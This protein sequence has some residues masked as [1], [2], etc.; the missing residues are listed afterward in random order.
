MIATNIICKNSKATIVKTIESVAQYTDFL[1]ITDTGSND[2]TQQLIEETCKRLNFPYKLTDFTWVDDFSVARNFNFSQVPP[3]ADWLFWLDSD[4]IIETDNPNRMRDL[5]KS[6]PP[7]LGAFWFPYHYAFDEFGNCTTMFIRERL[8]RA[9]F[10]WKWQSRVH[11]TVSPIAQC[12]MAKD[13]SVRLRH[14]SAHGDRSERNFALLYRMLQE[15]PNHLRTWLYLGHQHFA[16]GSWQ[17]AISWYQKFASSPEVLPIERYQAL[18]YASR[19]A[20]SLNNPQLASNFALSALESYPEWGE[21]Y[22]LLSLCYN[23]MGAHAKAVFWGEQSRGKPLPEE[24]IFINPLDYTFNVEVAL[25]EGYAVLGQIDKA[26]KCLETAISIRPIK[27]LK[28]AQ[29][30]TFEVKAREAIVYGLKALCNNLIKEGELIKLQKLVSIFPTWMADVPDTYQMMD[31]IYRTTCNV[32]IPKTETKE[33]KEVVHLGTDFF[34][35]GVL[36]KSYHKELVCDGVL[37]NVDV[38]LSDAMFR[39]E[40]FADS[41]TVKIR[42]KGLRKVSQ[43]ELERAI[44]QPNRNI[45]QLY[46]DEG[47]LTANFNHSVPKNTGLAIRMFLGNA[48]E[49]WDPIFIDKE[50]FGGSEISAAWLLKELSRRGNRTVLYALANGMYDSVLYRTQFNPQHPPCDLFISSRVPQVLDAPI[51]AAVKLLWVHDVHCGAGLTPQI[52]DKIDGIVVLSKWHLRFMKNIYPWLKDCEVVDMRGDPEMYVDDIP[53]QQGYYADQKLNSP[54]RIFI[55]CDAIESQKWEYID[56][57]K[58]KEFPNRFVWM[59]AP[60]RG[61]EQ[62]LDMWEKIKS[63]LP[64]AELKIFYGWQFFDKTLHVPEQKALKER[65]LEKVKQPGVEWVGRVNPERLN[66]ELYKAGLWLYPPPHDFRETC[67]I[68]A[69]EC[70]AAGVLCF[71]RMNGALGEVL[72]DRGVPLPLTSTQDEIVNSIINVLT[73]PLR[74]STMRLE[75]RKWAMQRNYRHLADCFL[76]AYQLCKDEGKK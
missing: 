62:I 63:A 15:D 56:V 24:V 60:D 28:D 34:T 18:T 54:P 1:N 21:A 76:K 51:P 58:P 44:A 29:D 14:I 36:P 64:G 72:G 67:C 40:T 7:E 49:Y 73:D 41:I 38:A 13:A 8:L 4:D 3:E 69:I 61:L 2:G 27:E 9:C 74:V 31:G 16:G 52:A 55:I 70:Q 59:S 75:G 6:A 48:P 47:V 20:M 33:A 5:T 25:F 50:G 12:A 57:N 46:N 68:S 65:L 32:Q 10:G 45:T 19:A 66:T 26:L 53:I 35:E 11:E 37:E 17:E 42:P 43:M 71:Y 39:I 22:V 23:R 30:R